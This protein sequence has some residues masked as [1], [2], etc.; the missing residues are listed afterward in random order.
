M[1]KSP[2]KSTLQTQ[3]ILE[4]PRPDSGSKDASPP[5]QQ[6]QSPKLESPPDLA[7][8]AKKPEPKKPEPKKP[9]ANGTEKAAPA[10]NASPP[11]VETTNGAA[12]GKEPQKTA[13]KEASKPTV[14]TT[15]TVPKPLAAASASK[16]TA[17][18]EKSP[19]AHKGPRS[20]AATST[21]HAAAKKT[22]EKK[23]QPPEKPVTPRTT[24]P[25]KSAGP[26]SIKKPPPL[27][28]SPASTGFVKP[29]VK[30]PTRPVK[31]PPGLTTHTASSGGKVSVPR[32]S[33][34]RGSG[35]VPPAESRGRPA[36][37][38]SASTAG[39]G[40][41]AAPT[42]GLRRQSSTI[43]RPRPSLG[44]P[45]K[46]PAKDHPPT[47]KEKEVDQGFLA[48]MMRPTASSASKTT[49]KVHTS[50]PRRTVA[51]PKKVAAAKP[52]KKVLPK[53]ASAALAS[54]QPKSS[55]ASLVTA[56]VENAST[57]EEV[58]E[59]AKAA[60]GEVGLPAEVDEKS[61]AQAVAPVVE[62]SETVEEV[63]A[64]VEEAGDEAVLPQAAD[65]VV[66]ESEPAVA[67]EPVAD[68]HDSKTDT[69]V[70]VGEEV[71]ANAETAETEGKEGAP[72]TTAA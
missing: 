66:I 44:P 15:K 36:S 64:A 13:V 49:D 58:V 6:E 65:A 55:S 3:P 62:Q 7:V 26:S 19:T 33:L 20:P 45:P 46:Q 35:S 5:V 17:K 31:L 60:E 57:A 30:S 68:A 23:A 11:Q 28:S 56:E 21:H 42:K 70:T 16:T 61:S 12:N 27:Q 63:T 48:R 67:D 50:P 18:A 25:S 8:E 9:E 52:V 59:S 38:A 4:S 41:K 14:R 72:E 71:A 24:A 40:S 53:T 29:K 47:R 10:V 54:A 22:P 39:S 2:A 32:Q 43:N 51:A 37:R 34:S 69:A 1:T